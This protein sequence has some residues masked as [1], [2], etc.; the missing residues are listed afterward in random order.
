MWSPA[1]GWSNGHSR[2]GDRVRSDPVL[3]DAPAWGV[4][5][6]RRERHA[7]TQGEQIKRT[8]ELPLHYAP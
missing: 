5:D 2:R 7:E 8:T 1:S 4:N 3:G 6:I